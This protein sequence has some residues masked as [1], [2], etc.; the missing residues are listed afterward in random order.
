MPEPPFALP[1]RVRWEPRSQPRPTRGMGL[2][3]APILMMGRA[4]RFSPEIVGLSPPP[5]G[6]SSVHPRL[7]RGLGQ[8]HIAR[9]VGPV[10]SRTDIHDTGVVDG[11]AEHH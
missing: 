2:G 10:V 1:L 5:R 7:G 8:P 4:L 3:H 11:R 6:Q 9:P